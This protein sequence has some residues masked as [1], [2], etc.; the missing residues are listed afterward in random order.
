MVEN[1]DLIWSK[2]MIEQ[3]GLRKHRHRPMQ[4]LNLKI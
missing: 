2:I 1:K 4:F 3:I